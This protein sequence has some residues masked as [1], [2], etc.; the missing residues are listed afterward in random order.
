MGVP[1]V[2]VGARGTLSSVAHDRSGYLVAPADVNAM[3]HHSR[4][5]L[6]D[7]A[8]WGRLS[9]GARDFASGTTPA[10]VAVRVLDVYAAALGM[11]RDVPFPS[12]AGLAAAGLSA[13]GL[14]AAPQS[15]L[16]YDQ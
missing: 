4:A 8:L 6:G 15:T 3:V 1:V 12:E 5:I 2:A 13:A 10:G 11:P 14:G 16:A 7:A 9:A